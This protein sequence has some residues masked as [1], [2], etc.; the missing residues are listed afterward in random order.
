MATSPACFSDLALLPPV[1]GMSR[2]VVATQQER[3][4]SRLD[5]IQAGLADLQQVIADY[6]LHSIAVPPFGCG[7]GDCR[8]DAS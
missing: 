5:D 1:A 2:F 6:G 8:R 4:N 3:S 7:N